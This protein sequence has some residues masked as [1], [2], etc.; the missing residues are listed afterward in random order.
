M[1]S[2]KQQNVISLI[3][4]SKNNHYLPIYLINSILALVGEL[5]M[6]ILATIQTRMKRKR[7]PIK[8]SHK[9]KINKSAVRKIIN[10]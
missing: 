9:T 7:D 5:M 1:I 2:G 3:K 8:K 10:N 4:K 6:L